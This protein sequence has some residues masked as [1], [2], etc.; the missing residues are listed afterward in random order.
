[1]RKLAT[2]SATPIRTSGLRRSGFIVLIF[3]SLV[4]AGY[5]A[6]AYVFLTL[7]HGLHPD[8]R[9]TF[10][11]YS[12]GIYTHVF[13]SIVALSLGAFQFSKRLRDT[14]LALH[15]WL[16]RFYLAG[17]LVGGVSGFF[18][19]FHAYGGFVSRLGFGV[20]AIAWLYTGIQ[21]Y[22]SIRAKDIVSHRRWMIRNFSLTFA[23]V[24]LRLWIPIFIAAGIP[25][26]VAY[27][28]A[29]W[30]CW[31]PNLAAAELLFNQARKVS[32]GESVR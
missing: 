16:G 2:G 4:V 19:A 12:V 24:T 20:L 15:R 1:M 7:G 14:R 5:A 9:A 8:L 27:H 23:A 28:I 22:L 17:V 32:S 31:V 25:Y 21:A 26:E 18:M 30:L 29:A 6:F 11:A 3:L 10:E 13:A